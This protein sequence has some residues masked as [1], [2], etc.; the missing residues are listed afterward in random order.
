MDSKRRTPDPVI[1][2]Q[3]GRVRSF[4]G[5]GRGKGTHLRYLGYITPAGDALRDAF[6]LTRDGDDAAGEQRVY[7]VDITA[8]GRPA[9][10]EEAEL[11][12]SGTSPKRQPSEDCDREYGVKL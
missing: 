3:R 1:A 7:L 6:L 2:M 10:P 5:I 9:S 8:D 12:L 4:L 11:C